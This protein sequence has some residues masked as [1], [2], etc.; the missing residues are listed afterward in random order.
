MISVPDLST[1]KLKYSPKEQI[2]DTKVVDEVGF[3]IYRI[4][5]TPLELLLT[6]TV[7]TDIE[8]LR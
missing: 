4:T 6:N 5:V 7:R 2:N 1:G 8:F 3:K